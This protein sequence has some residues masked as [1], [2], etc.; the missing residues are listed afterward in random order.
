MPEIRW[1]LEFIL[2]WAFRRE[3][4]LLLFLAMHTLTTEILYCESMVRWDDE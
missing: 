4:F 1:A 3:G 2:M